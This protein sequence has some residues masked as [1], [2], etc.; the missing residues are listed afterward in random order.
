MFRYAFRLH[1]WGMVGFGLL[2]GVVTLVQGAA[3]KQLAGSTPQSRALFGRQMTALAEQLSYLLPAPHQVETIAG[4]VQ[5][6]AWG[7]LPLVVSIWAI[8]SATAAVRGDE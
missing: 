6:R 2:L 1:R 3:Y 8:A 5:W 7:P 4:Y